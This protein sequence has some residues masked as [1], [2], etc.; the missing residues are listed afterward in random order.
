MSELLPALDGLGTPC[1]LVGGAV[2]DLLRGESS[3]DLDLALADGAAAAATVLAERLGGSSVVHDEFATATVRAGGLVVDLATTRRETYESP[4]ALPAVEPAPLGEDLGRRD[5]TINAM[6]IGLTGEDLGRLYDPLGGQADLDAGLIRVLH[7]ASF[8]DDPTRLLRALRYE[9]RL[10][11][12]LDDETERLARAAVA[13][14]ALETVS[15]VRVGVELLDLLSEREAAAAVARLGELG[16]DRALQPAVK[17]DPELVAGA[18]LA[19]LEARARL[20][21]TALA[22]LIAHRPGVEP[23]PRVGVEPGP[24]AGVEEWVGGLGLEAAERDAVLRAAGI[25][26]GLAEKL[27]VPLR[28]SELHELLERE[29]AEAL[30]L[31]LALGAPEERVLR[32]TVGLSLVGLEISGAD[33]LAAGIP[34]SPAIGLA[35]RET[36]RRKLDGELSGRENELSTALALAREAAGASR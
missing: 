15:G 33:M 12:A 8:L 36:L 10:G 5:F 34:E 23:G 14:G 24:R 9:S 30:A 27:R 1:H 22:A 31:A 16:I 2:R 13:A 32:Y 20:A 28:D 21:L 29:P 4:G 18:R 19:A 35:L 25:A 7:P 3:A 6:A 26:A 11:F 17:A